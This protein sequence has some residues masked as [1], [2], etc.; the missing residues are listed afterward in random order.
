MISLI[1]CD[2]F[3]PDAERVRELVTAGK[4]FS[5]DLK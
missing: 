4:F 3:A 1:Q 5:K 2:D